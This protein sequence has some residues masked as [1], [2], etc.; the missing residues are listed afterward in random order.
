MRADDSSGTCR[1]KCACTWP[2]SFRAV[3]NAIHHG[4]AKHVELTLSLNGA[5]R[6]QVEDDGRGIAPDATRR[7]VGGLRNIDVR[8]QSLGG[9]FSVEPRPGGG[10]ALRAEIPLSVATAAV[11]QSLRR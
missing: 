4:Q 3:R 5:L 2:A 7:S 6:I 11:V 8:V 10:P 1:A 9:T